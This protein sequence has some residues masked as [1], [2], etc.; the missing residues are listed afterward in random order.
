MA[1]LMCKDKKIDLI[2]EEYD[3]YKDLVEEVGI[4]IIYDLIQTDNDGC[5]Y[6]LNSPQE[7]IAWKVLFFLQ[8]LMINQRLRR[9]EKWAK[10]Q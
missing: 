6:M 8:N 9:I 3:V 4:D 5:I 7:V 1:I 2:D 10:E